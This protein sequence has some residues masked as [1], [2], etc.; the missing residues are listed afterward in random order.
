MLGRLGAR[1]AE[2]R[3]QRESAMA[4]ITR[5]ACTYSWWNSPA[6]HV[7]RAAHTREAGG[8]AL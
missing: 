2:V 1:K 7:R 6:S 5:C 3:M 4:P 8:A